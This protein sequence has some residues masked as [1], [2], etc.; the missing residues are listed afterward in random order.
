HDQGAEREGE[1]N[2]ESNVS[3]IEH[4]RMDDHLGI[5]QERIES[6]AVGTKWA[7]DEAE[8]IRGETYQREKEN[9]D[10]SQNHR[11]VGEKAGISFV[12]ETKDECVSGEQERPEEQRAFLSGPQGCEFVW[13]G[14]GAVAVVKDV[15]VGEVVAERGDDQD[16]GSQD[17]G[18]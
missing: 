17:N 3:E 16:H 11:R 4:G 7:F 18:A 12:P 15:S 8:G 1:W 9:L 6:A 10:A 14:K 2:G 13:T 5:L